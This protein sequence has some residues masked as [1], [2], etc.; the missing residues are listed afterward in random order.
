[1]KK[2]LTGSVLVVAVMA[3]FVGC[4]TK[5]TE[6]AAKEEVI[7]NLTDLAEVQQDIGANYDPN[8]PEATA[9]IMQDY[10][11]LG[12]Q[13]E[14]DEFEKIESLD[15]PSG[16]P[17]SLVYGKGKVTSVS[18]DGDET[19]VNQ[20]ITIQTT[21]DV[22]TVKDFYKNLLSQSA[23]KITSQSSESGGASYSV[24]ETATNL[25]AGIDITSDAYSK[26]VSVYIWYSGS[27]GE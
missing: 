3:F 11:E 14:L 15:L 18:D 8:D 13:M 25:E 24:T 19:Y 20:S 21:E 1:M 26:L 2:T 23:W 5:S 22:K 16:F 6:E 10:A 27:V 17:S 12:A 4:G 7:K 9:K